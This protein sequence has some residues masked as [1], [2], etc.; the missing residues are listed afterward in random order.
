MDGAVYLLIASI[1]IWLVILGYLFYLQI[2][3]QKL[4]RKLQSLMEK[5]REITG[6]LDKI[7]REKISF[8]DVNQE[9]SGRQRP[10]HDF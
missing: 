6:S 8:K 1:I 2:S 5:T 9:D 3:L 4:N 7:I 10:C